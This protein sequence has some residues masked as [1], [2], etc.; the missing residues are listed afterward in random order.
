MPKILISYR[1]EDSAYQSGSIR[2]WLAARFGRENVFID[3]DSI[4]P[5][6]DFRSHLDREVTAC[7][8]LIAVIGKVW[9]TVCDATG[10]RRLDDPADFVRLE[11]EAALKR[12]I[13]VIPVLVDNMLPPRADQLPESLCSLAYRNAIPVRPPPDFQHDVEKLALSIESQDKERRQGRPQGAAKP[14]PAPPQ[15]DGRSRQLAKPWLAAAAVICLLGAALVVYVLN[16][17]PQPDINGPNE[18][19]AKVADQPIVPQQP[20]PP[21]AAAPQVVTAIATSSAGASGS[22][23][24]TGDKLK[25]LHDLFVMW[26]IPGSLKRDADGKKYLM[27]AFNSLVTA[28]G[29]KNPSATMEAWITDAQKRASESLKAPTSDFSYLQ[30]STAGPF[31]ALGIEDSFLR[32]WQVASEGNEASNMAKVRLAMIAFVGED[33]QQQLIGE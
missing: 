15:F 10:R 19:S 9:L 1:R 26:T 30:F 17:R 16:H 27:S 21:T 23:V 32:L 7:D 24:S 28:S 22:S 14:G 8:Y 13:P 20:A 4:P 2:D 5:G 3:V 33:R 18:V 25:Y 11:L 6:V 12:D 31:E 29:D